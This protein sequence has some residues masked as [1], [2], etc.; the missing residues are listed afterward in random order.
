MNKY[1]F[2]VGVGQ[3]YRHCANRA[4]QEPS[5]FALQPYENGGAF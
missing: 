3:K 5:G 1:S 2:L 4:A